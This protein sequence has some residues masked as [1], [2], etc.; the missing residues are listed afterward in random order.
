[1]RNIILI[2]FMGAGKTTV[3]K[4]L[5]KERELAFVDTDERIEREQGRKIP[6][7]FARDGEAYFRDLET[8]LLQKMQEDTYGSVIS[9]GGGMPVREQNR[10]LLRSLGCVI[11]LS[12]AK[13]TILERVKRD[14]SRPMLEGGSLEERV[15]RLMRE[16]ESFYR[17]AAHIDV[18]TD[19]RSVRQVL[20]IIGQETRKYGPM[21]GGET[22]SEEKG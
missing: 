5:A 16:R 13:E 19:G 18:R 7:I 8:E 12:A 21:T 17:Q 4:L 11:Y 15:E 14:G 1:M 22:L 20:Q 10:T 6:D 9:V 2:G 3:G